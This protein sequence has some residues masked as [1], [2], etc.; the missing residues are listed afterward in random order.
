[1]TD[2]HVHPWDPAQGHPWI[3]PGSPHHRALTADALAAS[4]A[5]LELSGAILAASGAG[6]GPAGAILVEASQGDRAENVLLRDLRLRHPGLILGHVGNLNTCHD[7]GPARFADLLDRTRPNGMRLGGAS[8]RPRHRAGGRAL[9]P[10]LA[11]HG[12]PEERVAALVGHAVAEFGPA[13]CMIG[14]HGPICLARG[15]RAAS[16]RLAG[17]G[18]AALDDAGRRLVL[19]GGRRLVLSGA[20][21][22]AY[23]LM[24]QVDNDRS[25]CFDA[26]VDDR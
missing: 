26:P 15:S 17:R 8:G 24:P 1:M 7:L 3:R 5:G 22:R 21:R 20:A 11:R 18:P 13:R 10:L 25:P 23:G 12:V 16:L 4:G 9:V 6:P 2:C 19:S 14:S